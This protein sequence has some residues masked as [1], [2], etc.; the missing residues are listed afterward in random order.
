MKQKLAM[1]VLLLSCFTAACA[2]I[3]L[4][5][6]FQSGMVLQRNQPIPVWGTADAGE[7][8]A[9]TFR[10][11]HYQATADAQGRWRVDLPR[12][13][14]GG[15]FVL[16]VRSEKPGVSGDQQEALQFNDVL[17]GD[18]WL[19][20]GQ[21][22]IDVT[23][24]RVYP[25]YPDEIDHF[26]NPNVRLFRVQ[27]ETN[28]HGPQTD[29]RPTAINWKP[30]NKQN[31][32][33]F[34]A[35]GTFLGQRMFHETR[36]PQGIIVNSWGGTPI[37]AWVSADSLRRDYPLL[38][39]QTRLWQDDQLVVAQQQ[40]N[41]RANDRWFQLLN[42]SDPRPTP[43][44]RFQPVDQYELPQYLKPYTQNGQ[45]VGS[46]WVQQHIYINKE[47]AGRAARLLLG[48]LFDQ[49]YTFLNGHEVG[50]TYYQYPP[51]RYQI[52]EGILHEGDNTLLIRFVNK[53]GV[54]H[55]IEEKP[56]MLIFAD[57]DTLHLGRQW[58]A[59]VGA[60]MPACPSGG[61]SLQNLPTTLYNAVLYPLA[62]Y[63]LSGVVWYQGESNTGNPQ[64]YADLLKKLMGCWRDRWQQPDLPFCVVQLANFMAPSAQPQNSGW[65]RLR[66]AQ[67]TVAAAD[68]RSELAV[69]IDLGETVDIHPLRKKEVAERI[70][71]CMD[72]LVFGKKVALSPQV[73]GATVSGTDVVLTFDQPL[74]TATT[75]FEFEVAGADGR[76]VNAEA[77]AEGHTVTLKSPI[78][79]AR[80]VRYGWKDNPIRANLYGQN[81]PPAA[82]FEY[83]L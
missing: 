41:Q 25:Q 24:E 49:D 80:S 20:S 2:K 26:D 52:P 71:L 6:L 82:P 10:K 57:G 1:L 46:V 62:P 47:R 60:L 38:V 19:C 48:T 43:A 65:A 4:P 69:T 30:L 73:T 77:R 12:Q 70:G 72:R 37:E 78:S 31:A 32:W 34:S 18:V 27:N 29:I 50:R 75:L 59:R 17:I 28:T 45:F 51:R 40:A 11:K 9:V 81:G 44:D 7:P 54:P 3:Q 14:A 74:R 79:S 21:S 5:Q 22:N 15:P 16:E 68:P 64:P 83:T 39:E 53:Y 56:Y 66:E 36:V 58:E 63:A 67:R 55:F 33:L 76:Y 42:E 23:I 8:I 61:V 35:V 13:K